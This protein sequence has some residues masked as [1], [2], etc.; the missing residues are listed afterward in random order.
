MLQAPE[1]VKKKI[2]QTQGCF[3]PQRREIKSSGP[4]DAAESKDA[5]APGSGD[6]ASLGDGK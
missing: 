5:P 1:K 6:A 2:S 3:E 4:R